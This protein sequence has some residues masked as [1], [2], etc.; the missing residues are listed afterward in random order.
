MLATIDEVLTYVTT[1]SRSA[2]W[3]S[4]LATKLKPADHAWGQAVLAAMPERTEP[5]MN[6][7]SLTI[8]PALAA[9]AKNRALMAELLMIWTNAN[10]T[11]PD[12]REGLFAAKAARGL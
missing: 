4:R 9:A 6:R 5:A 2:A 8:A 1:E 10:V 12:L 3:Y 7:A 11:A